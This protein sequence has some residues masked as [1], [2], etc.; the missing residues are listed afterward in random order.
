MTNTHRGKLLNQTNDHKTSFREEGEQTN[1]NK[2]DKSRPINSH[3]LKHISHL[4]IEYANMR[5]KTLYISFKIKKTFF[6][7]ILEHPKSQR[8]IKKSS[9]SIFWRLKAK[10]EERAQ[11][12][13]VLES[14]HK[15]HESLHNLLS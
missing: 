11:Q 9:S 2:L 12:N 6:N 10:E 15:L 8:R 14:I 7:N 3:Y 5:N 4:I 13:V 1:S